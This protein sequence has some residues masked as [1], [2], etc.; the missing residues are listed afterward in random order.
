MGIDYFVC[1]KCGNPLTQIDGH[2]TCSVCGYSVDVGR[3]RELV[4]SE[5][6]TENRLVSYV[7]VRRQ[8][9]LRTPN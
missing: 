4:L 1:P 5:G 2:L 7:R 3:A 8:G 9:K 6:A